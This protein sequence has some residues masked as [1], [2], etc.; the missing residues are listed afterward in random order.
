MTY[1]FLQ[2]F[3]ARGFAPESR[4]TSCS[5]FRQT[6]PMGA[7]AYFL[8]YIKA[9][10]LFTEARVCAAEILVEV[11]ADAINA[12]A[13][14][15]LKRLGTFRLE[16]PQS[17]FFEA[18][19]E[20]AVLEYARTEMPVTSRECYDYHIDPVSNPELITS[21]VSPTAVIGGCRLWLLQKHEFPQEA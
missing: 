18:V 3:W 4:L 6:T 9:R 2:N 11:A 10:Q 16:S 5:V 20:E 1:S 14:E 21:R 8:V 13:E 15:V 17:R 7:E 12:H 19:V